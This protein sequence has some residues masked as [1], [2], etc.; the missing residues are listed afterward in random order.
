MLTQAELDFYVYGERDLA[1]IAR[2]L[3]RANELKALE[4]KISISKMLGADWKEEQLKKLD[5]VMKK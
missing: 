3:K 4:L 1:D 2:E 5:E